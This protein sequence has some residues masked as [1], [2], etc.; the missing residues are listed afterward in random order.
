MTESHDQYFRQLSTQTSTA[1]GNIQSRNSNVSQR[2]NNWI[3]SPSDPRT[4]SS[5]T[6][7]AEPT[8]SDFGQFMQGTAFLPTSMAHSSTQYDNIPVTAQNT[9]ASSNTSRCQQTVMCTPHP[10]NGYMFFMPEGKDA[11]RT[12]VGH[13]QGSFSTPLSTSTSRTPR[14]AFQNVALNSSGE[15][16]ISPVDLT[17]TP[18][19]HTSRNGH[20]MIPLPQFDVDECGKLREIHNQK[21]RR[22]RAR[23][24]EACNLLRQLVPGMS[25]KTDKATVFEFAARYVHFLKSH[26]GNQF[27]KDFLMKYSPY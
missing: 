15:E 27:D 8:P 12:P 22:R 4:Q 26:T 21:E 9:S 16:A 10:S 6:S 20:S 25:D 13:N 14:S 23:I 7:Q 19:S 5:A 17:N 1:E 11:G 24:K 2:Y 3:P 18:V